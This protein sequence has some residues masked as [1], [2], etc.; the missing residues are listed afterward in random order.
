M[1]M[2]PIVVGVGALVLSLLA[3]QPGTAASQGAQAPGTAAHDHLTEVACVDGRLR[4]AAASHGSSPRPALR[5]YRAARGTGKRSRTSNC[6]CPGSPASIPPSPRVC[7][8]GSHRR[9]PNEPRARCARRRTLRLPISS[10]GPTST[11]ADR[12][13]SRR[14]RGDHEARG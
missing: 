13:F 10:R 14:R 4:S 5:R 3:L 11:R 7:S 8:A 12:D 6:A 2:N 1:Q 9:D